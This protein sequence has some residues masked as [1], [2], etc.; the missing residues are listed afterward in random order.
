[1]TIAR[2]CASVQGFGRRPRHDVAAGTFICGG[3]APCSTPRELEAADVVAD[4]SVGEAPEKSRKSL[5]I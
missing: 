2:R 5:N 1:M 3:C 4:R